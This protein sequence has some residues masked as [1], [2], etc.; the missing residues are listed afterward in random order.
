MKPISIL[1]MVGGALLAISCS[2]PSSDSISEKFIVKQAN[3][4]LEMN[5][6]N[7]DYGYITVGEYECNDDSDREELR[8]LEAAGLITYDVVRYAWWEKT[9]V[10]R[11]E[12]HNVDYYYTWSGAYAYTKTEYRTVKK[13]DYNFFDHYIVK[14]AL[15]DK[16]EKYVV[17]DIP[18]PVEDIDEDMVEKEVDP[19]TYAWNQ[20][21][22]S[23]EW[24]YIS[25][26]FIVVKEPADSE[27]SSRSSSSSSSSRS[28]GSAG[29]PEPE[30][31]TERID[32]LQ[33]KNYIAFSE[34]ATQVIVKCWDV[35]CFKARNIQIINR[36]GVA[37]ATAEVLY[38]T[39]N[40]TDFG[41][42]LKNGENDRKYSE[43][44]NFA[45]YQD[46]GWVTS[47]E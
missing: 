9:L 6:E 27:A 4:Q 34:D 16:G 40:C 13:T 29:K 43:N 15:T 35:E 11:K 18:D 38:R 7:C 42:I 46:K 37:T 14:V 8:M 24:P 44:I 32:S 2:R 36:D 39:K 30:D 47:E 20:A 26:P 10:N 17:E 31:K 41:R 3:K 1:L 23:E 19:S 5:V 12:P 33:Y 45:F 28:S 25:N 21:D 22:L